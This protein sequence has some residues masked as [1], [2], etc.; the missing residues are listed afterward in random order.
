MKLRLG[1]IKIRDIQFGDETR[2][3]Q[4]VLY[5]N[6]EE[7]LAA[8]ADDRL[9]SIELDL[10]RPGESI[11][12]MPVKDVIEPRLKLESPGGIFPGLS[13]RSIWWA[14]GPPWSSAA[15]PW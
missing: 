2:V 1:R 11:R 6:K 12:I 9:S 15:P 5:V 3:S 10:A 7:I 8:V 4:G 14:K 13:A